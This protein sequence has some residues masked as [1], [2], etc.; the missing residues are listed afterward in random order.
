[1]LVFGNKADNVAYHELSGRKY[2][3]SGRPDYYAGIRWEVQADGMTPPA[4]EFV[5]RSPDPT[6]AVEKRL[7][8]FA[9]FLEGADRFVAVEAFSEINNAIVAAKYR[10]IATL[11]PEQIRGWMLNP[12][13]PTYRRSGYGVM[14]GMC[15]GPD[16]AAVLERIIARPEKDDED[17]LWMEGVM[18]GYLLLN[19]ESG[20]KFLES[21]VLADPKASDGEIYTVFSAIRIVRHLG[22]SRIASERLNTTVKS[23]LD[24]PAFT[25]V[26][27]IDLASAKDWS[28]QKQ[29]FERFGT[30]DFSDRYIKKAIIGY[31]IASTKDVPKNASEKLPRHVSDGEKYLEELRRT[32][33]KLVAE[34]EKF[35]YLR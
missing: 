31:L 5:V 21:T 20:L 2:C 11:R 10:P 17:W 6:I 33:P 9:K 28:L 22:N 29:L 13:T 30:A 35:F 4:I 12:K 18:S 7:E 1:M 8:Y 32:D 23:M 34:V 14:L 19:G 3:Q 24:R 26:I 25:D 15:G 16:D 27:I